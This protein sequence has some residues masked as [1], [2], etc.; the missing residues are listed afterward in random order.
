MP[1]ELGE[2]PCATNPRFLD[3]EKVQTRRLPTCAPLSAAAV[4]VPLQWPNSEFQDISRDARERTKA[5]KMITKIIRKK[6]F[7]L[8]FSQT[9]RYRE[10]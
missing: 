3:P 9:K 5:A 10:N 1:G 7:N 2:P 6:T 4:S 8:Q